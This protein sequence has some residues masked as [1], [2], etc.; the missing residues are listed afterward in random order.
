MNI[1]QTS[2]IVFIAKLVG[3]FLGFVATLVFA[4]V[5][6]ADIY[7]IYILILTVVSWLGLFGKIGLSS[8]IKKR[9]SEAEEQ[10]AYLT[11]G[12]ILIGAMALLI[13]AV[14]VL[15]RPL[16]EQYF[17]DFNQ[18]IGY[19]VVWFLILILIAKLFYKL[20]FNVLKAEQKVH[21]GTILESTQIGVQSAIQVA[22]VLVGFGL[23]GMLVGYVIGGVLVGIVGL[24][25]MNSRPLKPYKSH[26]RSLLE[27]AKYSWLGGFKSKAFNDIDILLLGAFA[28][29]ALVGIYAIAWSLAKFLTLFSRAIH[30]TMFPE[31][32]FTSAQDSPEAVSGLIEDSLMYSGLIGIPGLVG[33]VLLADRLLL[34]YGPTFTRGATVL[35]LLLL[36]V[37]LYSYY[38]QLLNVLNA[39]DRPDVAF[40]INSMFI[41]SNAGLNIPLILRYGIEGAAIASVGSVTLAVTLSYFAVNRL[42]EFRTPYV[43]ISR[44]IGASLLM[45]V[46][47]WTALGTIE[48]MGVLTN[49]MIMVVS[50]V[51]IGAVSYFLI[52]LGISPTFRETIDRNLPFEVQYLR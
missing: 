42:V 7:G 28:S 45:G 5:V 31:I 41:I 49:N 33:G 43:E 50:L 27:Y 17:V 25:W 21:I 22:L 1:G 12:A 47:V 29:S 48:T 23:L 35:G 24:Y 37:L 38:T 40:W 9:I 10:G 15:F 30:Q 14:V 39:I 19:S 20:I 44:Q 34:I 36:S 18:Y 2:L 8:A 52:L 26:F 3:A 4:R 46:I 6:G 11:A 13:S 16:V 51:A 32:S